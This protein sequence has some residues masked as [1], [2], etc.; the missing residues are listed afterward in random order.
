MKYCPKCQTCKAT[1]EFHPNRSRTDGLSGYCRLCSRL[2]TRASKQRNEK[3]CQVS[4]CES[5]DNGGGHCSAHNHRLRRHGDV[6]G[7]PRAPYGLPPEERFWHYVDKTSSPKGCWLWIGARQ[8][9]NGGRTQDG[10]VLYEIRNKPGDR[11]SMLAHRYAWFLK[12]GREPSETLDHT[13]YVRHCVN[14]DHLVEMTLE[15]NQQEGLKRR[16]LERLAFE[17]LLVQYDGDYTK[18]QEFLLAA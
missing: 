14:T 15:Q 12:Y 9:R 5:R 17:W 6:N 3:I 13:C 7:G 10:Y 2:A 18:L 4:K 1:S 16:R 11:K 8:S